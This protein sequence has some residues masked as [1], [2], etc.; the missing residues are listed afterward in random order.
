MFAPAKIVVLDDD[1]A[2]LQLV[3]RIFANKPEL[4]VLTE[5]DGER[6]LALI[7]LYQPVLVLLDLNLAG[8]SGETVLREL[9][10]DA[11]TV[12]IP[13]IMVSGDTSD[14]AKQ[15]VADAG[16]QGYLEKPYGISE[17]MELVSAYLDG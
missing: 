12:N 13:V 10:E 4:E 16:A 1:R 2:N 9:R 3:Q 14:T 8:M 6:G 15:R 11:T 5:L 17:L 7:R